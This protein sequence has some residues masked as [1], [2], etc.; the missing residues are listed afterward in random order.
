MGRSAVAVANPKFQ[1]EASVT[2]DAFD[3]SNDHSIDVS[4]IS[5]ERFC[6]RFAGGTVEATATIK[7]GDY[8]A[9]G[10][11]DLD[12]V[13]GSTAIKTITLETARFKDTDGLILIDL[14]S[15]GAADG[16]I[17]AYKLG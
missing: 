15:T 4:A 7:A 12:V 10:I 5:D 13:I 1:T 14:A 16:T 6:I 17:E 11:G 8:D 9:S 3:L 2:A